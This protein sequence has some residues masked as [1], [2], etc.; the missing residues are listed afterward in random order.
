M[1]D[2]I[3]GKIGHHQERAAALSTHCPLALSPHRPLAVLES[4]STTGPAEWWEHTVVSL[5]SPEFLSMD[6]WLLLPS[7]NRTKRETLLPGLQVHLEGQPK[8]AMR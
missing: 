7:R 5:N 1:R 2:G 4:S 8:L 3:P 6:C